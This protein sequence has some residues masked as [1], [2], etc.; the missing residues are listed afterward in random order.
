MRIRHEDDYNKTIAE[1]NEAVDNFISGDFNRLGKISLFCVRLSE[2][3]QYD[4]SFLLE[5]RDILLEYFTGIYENDPC[6]V[7]KKNDKVYTYSRNSVCKAVRGMHTHTHKPD[8][9]SKKQK[10]KHDILYSFMNELERIDVLYAVGLQWVITPFIR[11]SGSP[12]DSNRGM[13]DT[14]TSRKGTTKLSWIESIILNTYDE[15]AYIQNHNR[16]G[17]NQ[18]KVIFPI[19]EIYKDDF[20]NDV[21]EKIKKSIQWINESNTRT[22][23]YQ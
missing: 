19:T 16:I 13:I 17:F 4:E 6:L 18:H 15:I 10:I 7:L 3:L 14:F 9:K 22:E 2:I 20:G 12:T 21:Y 23:T 5:P 1:A 8:K 11:C